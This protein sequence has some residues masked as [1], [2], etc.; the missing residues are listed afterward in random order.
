MAKDTAKLK[1]VLLNCSLKSGGETSNT[2]ALL[3]KIASHLKDD[4]CACEIV[5]VADLHLPPGVKTSA[6]DDKDDFP[7]LYKKLKAADVVVM[8]TPIWLGH[9]GS[10]MQR[11]LERLDGSMKE[12]DAKGRMPF[13]GKTAGVV[14]TG[15]EDGAHAVCEGVLFNLTHMGFT[16]PPLADCYWVGPAGPGPNYLDAGGEKHLYTNKTARYLAAGC[17]HLARV[18]KANPYDIDYKDLTKKAKAESDSK[19]Q[20]FFSDE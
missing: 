14:V 4:G 6:L 11:V 8:G 19:S 2:A 15:N 13:H 9:I 10:V 5:R 12:T 1:A 16:I 17:A 20:T 18:L 7:A 3:D